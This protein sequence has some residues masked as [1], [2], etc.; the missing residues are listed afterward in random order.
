M[1][2]AA[3]LLDTLEDGWWESQDTVLAIACILDD[4]GAF[5]SPGDIVSFFVKPRTWETEIAEIVR[6]VVRETAV[7]VAM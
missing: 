6:D 5:Q 4:F 3:G 7:R 1:E 2:E